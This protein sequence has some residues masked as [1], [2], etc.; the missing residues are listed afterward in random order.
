[1]RRITAVPFTR[2]TRTHHPC[3]P[4]ARMAERPMYVSHRQAAMR[5]FVAD[6]GDHHRVPQ[7]PVLPRTSAESGRAAA[8]ASQQQIRLRF[9]C[10]ARRARRHASHASVTHLS[11]CTEQFVRKQNAP[12]G[13]SNGLSAAIRSKTARSSVRHAGAT[14]QT[15]FLQNGSVNCAACS[16]TSRSSR[17]PMGAPPGQNSR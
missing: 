13:P 4:A 3:A 11:E 1:M 15:F 12:H 16:A 9:F 2:C 14:R 17:I 6:H 8:T 7:L 10:Y 5:A